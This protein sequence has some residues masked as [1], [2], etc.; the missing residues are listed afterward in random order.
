MIVL[1]I[2]PG[3][4]TTG[5]GIIDVGKERSSL[6]QYGCIVTSKQDEMPAR[7][8]TLRNALASIINSYKPSCIA[9]E[10]LFFGVNARSAMTVG[11]ARGVVMVTA[12]EWGL[13]IFEYQGLVVKL[14]LTG[15]GRA[16]KV[17]IQKAVA[18][19]LKVRNMPKPHDQ[20]GK[21]VWSFRDDAFDALAI[22]IYH[23]MQQRQNIE[24]TK[25]KAPRVSHLKIG[26]GAR[27]S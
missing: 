13:P 14:K 15:Y 26:Q 17:D 24:P 16:A 9:I 20:N 6:I 21:A 18:K 4:A 1:G 7:L 22:A 25:R 10:K 27:A 2:D 5:Y 11:Q 19:H 12:Q 8:L 3:T 23:T